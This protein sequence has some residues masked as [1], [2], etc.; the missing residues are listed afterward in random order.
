MESFPDQLEL[1]HSSGARL[2]ITLDTAELL[3][4]SAGVP[5]EAVRQEIFAIDHT[6]PASLPPNTDAHRISLRLNGKVHELRAQYP[7]TILGA[8]KRAGIP[9][10]YSCELG[11][12]GSCAMICRSGTVWMSKNEVLT[13]SDIR[14]GYVL[15]CT[16]YAV[17]GDVTLDG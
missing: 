6:A 13:D 14:N 9:L 8:A 12:C 11:Q 7:E 5:D 15:T 4:R 17:A 1:R 2:R 3:L 10:P 16:G